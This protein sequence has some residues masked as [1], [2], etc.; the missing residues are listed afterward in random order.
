MVQTLER[1]QNM[2][3]VAQTAEMEYQDNLHYGMNSGREEME[4]R[5]GRE[6][7]TQDEHKLS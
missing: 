1:S 4:Q 6:V 5:R 7:Y 2:L 3:R